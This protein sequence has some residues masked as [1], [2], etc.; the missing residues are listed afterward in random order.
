MFS[1]APPV[2]ASGLV[3]HLGYLLARLSQC[4]NHM[5][6]GGT[7]SKRAG[8][9]SAMRGAVYALHRYGVWALGKFSAAHAF[10]RRRRLLVGCL[11]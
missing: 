4:T 7:G 9:Q 3:L 11:V 2:K 1:L 5:L 8:K 6:P 10:G